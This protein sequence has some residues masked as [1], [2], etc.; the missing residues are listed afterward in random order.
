MS[1]PQ[2]RKPNRVVTQWLR[3]DPGEEAGEALAEADWEGWLLHQMSAGRI[4]QVDG[5]FVDRQV[6]EQ[7]FACVPERCAPRKGRGA[8]RSCCADAEVV[9]SRAEQSRLRR[10]EKALLAHLQPRE[11]RLADER[12]F[13]CDCGGDAL[14]RPGGRCAFSQLDGR[15]RIRCHLRAFA[16]SHGLEQSE[17]QPLSCRL[18]PL[19]VVDLGEGRTLLSVV[20]ASTRK[21]VSAHPPRRYPCLDDPGLPPLVDSMRADID[22]LFG[23]GFARKLKR[24]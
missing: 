13:W 3:G 24:A 15:G 8:R 14:A 22:W 12:A 4:V 18:F 6:L 20:S 2:S 23:A 19:I 9:L 21:L 1:H 5:I 17:I 7:R 11:P 16:R 10:H